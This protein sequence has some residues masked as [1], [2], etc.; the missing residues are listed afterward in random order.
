MRQMVSKYKQAFSLDYRII[1]LPLLKSFMKVGTVYAANDSHTFLAQ[2]Q[3]EKLI[4]EDAKQKSEAVAE[5]FLSELAL[6]AE[7]NTRKGGNPTKLPKETR[8]ANKKKSDHRKVKDPKATRGDE[9][10]VVREEKEEESHIPAGHDGYHPSSETGVA[11]SADELKLQEEELKHK[12]QFQ[13][14]ERKLEENLAHLRLIEEESKQKNLAKQT[15]DA[16]TL[17][18]D[19]WNV[20]LHD[21]SEIYTGSRVLKLEVERTARGRVM[22]HQD[23]SL[24]KST[25]PED[26]CRASASCSHDNAQQDILQAEKNLPLTTSQSMLLEAPLGEEALG[27]CQLMSHS[28]I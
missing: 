16:D 4:D 5:A 22:A 26:F 17:G 2:A 9:L 20:V 10:N 3:L 7:K 1:M 13:E 27:H 15:K 18:D 19:G 14:E 12:I 28:K 11:V 25:M 21:S 8:R 23:P 24:G 6:D